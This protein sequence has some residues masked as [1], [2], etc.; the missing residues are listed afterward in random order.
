MTDQRAADSG[1][2]LHHYDTSPFS[3]KVRMLFGLK[4]LGWH[5]VIQPNMMPKPDLVPLTGGYRRAPVMQVGADV[6]LDSSLALAEIERRHP[7]HAGG[8]AWPVNLWADRAFF[9]ASVA[10]IFGAI[11][12]KIDPAFAADREKLSGRPFDGA[13][14]AAAV[15]PAQ[16]A[17][18]AHA[19]WIES[20]L[21]SAPYLAG[22]APGIADVAAYMN[23]WFV[24]GF[25]P[26]QLDPLVEGMACL[27]V[28]RQAMAKV[29]QGTRTEMTT[30][31]ALAIAR[32]AAP[33]EPLAHD[34]GD[35]LGLSPG[36]AVTVAADD[37]G[38]DPVAGTLVALNASR[39]TIAREADGLGTLH[40]HAPRIG[41]VVARA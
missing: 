41:F 29:G 12:D 5:S 37:Y 21:S 26:K 39:V 20:A 17:W 33:A 27:K 11:G 4:N 25:Q 9:Q 34:A 28:W 16:A 2:I 7:G 22:E 15:V 32:D 1:F 18:R 8:A 24:G 23:L 31:D 19:A 13:A 3:Q 38:R 40:V 35:P 30:A 36:D 6:F 10:V 14:M